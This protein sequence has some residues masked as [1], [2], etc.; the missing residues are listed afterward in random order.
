MTKKEIAHHFLT[1][2][3]KGDSRTAFELYV[4]NE[5]K[6]H[7]AFFKGDRH[8]L[9]IAIEES[10]VTS[11]NKMFEIQHILEDGNLVSV[12]SKVQLEKE[13]ITLA[14]THIMQFEGDSIIELWDF[15]QAVPEEMVNENG[16]F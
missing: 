11:P 2:C 13:K 12:H 16:M 4:S 7:N 14:I 6:H 3:A 5:F 15:G 9:M 10:A 8:S 1:L